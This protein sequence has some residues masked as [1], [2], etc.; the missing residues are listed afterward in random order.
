MLDPNFQPNS[1]SI[2]EERDGSISI[3][4]LTEETIISPQDMFATLEKGGLQRTT[5]TTNM[6]LHSSR[7]H[8]I[9]TIHF[10]MREKTSEPTTNTE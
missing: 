9:Y 6:N 4:N 3:P 1:L 2:R 8:A 10:Q 5:A 7:S